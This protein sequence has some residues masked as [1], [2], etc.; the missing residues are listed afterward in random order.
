MAIKN[1]KTLTRF[2]SP[3]TSEISF[4]KLI[5]DTKKISSA[6]FLKIVGLLR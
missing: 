6:S 4:Q 3:L 1:G 5:R 2:F